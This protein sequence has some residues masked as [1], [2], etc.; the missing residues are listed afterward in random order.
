M[1]IVEESSRLLRIWGALLSDVTVTFQTPYSHS[2]NAKGVLKLSSYVIFSL[3]LHEI[4]IKQFLPTWILQIT[5]LFPYSFFFSK[6]QLRK[7]SSDCLGTL[8]MW[9]KWVLVLLLWVLLS[10][11]AL[12]V[13]LSVSLPLVCISACLSCV[14]QRCWSFLVHNSLSFSLQNVSKAQYPASSV[15]VV[16]PYDSCILHLTSYNFQFPKH[17]KLVTL[18]PFSFLATKSSII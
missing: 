10:F 15:T 13:T 11:G 3:S 17:L 4:P 2:W 6:G 7:G 16:L 5:K 18:D 14:I 1:A 9:E 8:A 12:S